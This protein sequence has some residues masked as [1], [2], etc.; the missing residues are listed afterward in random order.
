MSSGRINF[1][2]RSL[3]LDDLAV[4]RTSEG[5]VIIARALTYGVPYEVSDD[6][7]AHF[8]HEVWRSGV[9]DKSITQRSGRIPMLVTHDRRAL[10]IGA[11]IGM[12]ADRTAF[13]FRAKVSHTRGGDEALELIHDGALT[14]VSVGARLLNSR[15]IERGVERIEAALQEISLTP[16]AQMA[17]GRVLAVR[18]QVDPGDDGGDDGGDGDTGDDD[19]EGT[20]VLDEATAFLE[21]LTRP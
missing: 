3:E 1:V 14:G 13:V 9:F 20:P 18:A 5:R 8:Y 7:G 12:E 17:D 10:P 11:T 4:E 19:T 16:F 2:E 15:P 21:S 6:G